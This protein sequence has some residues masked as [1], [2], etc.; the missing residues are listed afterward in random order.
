M[1]Y[2]E[3]VA[4]RIRNA[5]VDEEGFREQKMFGGMCFL[6]NGNMCVGVLDDILV[7]RVGKENNAKALE[8]PFTRPMDFTGRPMKGFIYV[9]PEGFEKDDDLRDWILTAMEFVGTLPRK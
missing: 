7:I 8:K 3:D 6:L 9:D 1:A 4:N 2:S 5:L